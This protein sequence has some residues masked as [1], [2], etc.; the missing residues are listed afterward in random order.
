M[1]HGYVITT[2]AFECRLQD[3]LGAAIRGLIVCLSVVQRVSTLLADIHRFR[4]GGTIFPSFPPLDL[5]SLFFSMEFVYRAR[6]IM[7]SV[8][9][10]LRLPRG[11]F[12]NS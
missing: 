6:Q 7:H 5:Y 2:T 9:F 4:A 10:F 3:N 8:I 1:V 11:R 12:E